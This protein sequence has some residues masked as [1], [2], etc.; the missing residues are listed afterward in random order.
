MLSSEKK[1]AIYQAALKWADTPFRAHTELLGVGA[2]CVHLARGI[3][4]AA[5]F[6]IP[7]IVKR[8]YPLDWASHQD[9]SL[10]LA[11]VDASGCFVKLADN[12]TRQAG[13]LLCIRQGR[14]S[15]HVALMVDVRLFIHTRPRRF[16]EFGIVDDPTYGNRI[17]CT[18]RHVDAQ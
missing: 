17:A 13:D 3:L 7:P 6:K 5:G 8:D 10:V 1:S 16:A 18:Y 12:A 4:V 11:W 2:D 14:C 9:H 15:H